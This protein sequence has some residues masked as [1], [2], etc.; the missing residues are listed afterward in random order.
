MTGRPGII[1]DRD[2]TLIDFV[3]DE[4][5]GAVVS[6]FHPNQVRFFPGVVEGLR[7]LQDAGFVLSMATNQPGAAKGQVSLVA[8]TRTNDAVVER[9]AEQD[10]HIEAVEVCLHHTEGGPGGDPSLVQHCTCRKPHPGMLLSLAHKLDL[11]PAQSWMIGD[12]AVDVLAARSAGML[13]GLIFELGR[14][15]MCPVRTGFEDIPLIRPDASANRLDALA[16]II[17]NPLARRAD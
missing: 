10:V 13:A 5:L 3:R 9:L 14:C 8:I 17:L 11:D 6:A 7:A 16:R 1:L 15:E 12:A 2:G 4:E